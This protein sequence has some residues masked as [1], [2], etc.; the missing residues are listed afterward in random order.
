MLRMIESVN[1]G[2]QADE[3]GLK[4]FLL[5]CLQNVYCV[6]LKQT[7]MLPPTSFPVSY[8]ALSLSLSLSLWH[9]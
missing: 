3:V 7:T 8:L 1:F 5:G 4:D 2:L 6:T 9:I